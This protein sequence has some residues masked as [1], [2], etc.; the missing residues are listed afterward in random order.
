MGATQRTSHASTGSTDQAI[1][2]LVWSGS[3]A[4]LEAVLRLTSFAVLAR[5]IAPHEFGAFAAAMVVVEVIQFAGT[6]DLKPAL[7]QRPD[8]RDEHLCGATVYAL[9]VVAALAGLASLLAAPLA[10][11]FRIDALAALLPV[12]VWIPLTAAGSL[13]SIALLQRHF[14]FKQL[15]LVSTAGAALQAAVAIALAAAGAGLYALVWAAIVENVFRLLALR[16]LAPSSRW[17]FERQATVELLRFAGVV[18][19]GNLFQQLAL[20]GDRLIVGRWLGAASLGAYE[21]SATLIQRLVLLIVQMWSKLLLATASRA[22]AEPSQLRTIYLYTMTINSLLLL[23]ASALLCA[24]APEVVGAVLGPDWQ[25]AVAP[26]GVL[27]LSLFMVTGA[28]VS[29]AVVTATGAVKAVAR[30]KAVL[31]VLALGAVWLGQHLGVA[32]AAAGL[33]AALAVHWALLAQLGMRRSGLEWRAFARAQLPA[34][35]WTIAALAVSVPLSGLLRQLAW[36]PWARLLAVLAV[37]AVLAS[38]PLML[39][40]RRV[41]GREGAA[42]LAAILDI[43]RSRA[44][45]Q[46]PGE[47]A[48]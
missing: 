4:L 16:A 23:P 25:S 10:R 43:M 38:A 42:A 26:F 20:R 35:A 17:R 33:V 3:G 46:P 5:L 1:G 9:L 39:F 30:R 45:L 13:T 41:L 6:L 47:E 48:G 14:K 37:L 24:L 22:Q 15:M 28:E 40:R 11:L 44:A 27:A 36:A 31:A 34:L 7:V 8:L 32:G 2:A 18:S 21:R 12:V 19:L 29:D